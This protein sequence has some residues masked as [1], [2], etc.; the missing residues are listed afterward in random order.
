MSAR[1]DIR[2][3]IGEVLR[4]NTTAGANVFVSRTRKISAASLPAILV[5]TRQE[6]AEEFNTAPRELKRTLSVGIEIVA[7]ADD[8]LDDT[9]DDLAEEVER[10]LSENQLLADD[11]GS[12][13]RCSDVAY[14]GAEISLTADGDNQHGACVLS[15]DVTYHTL[16]VSEG[17]EGAGV[18]SYVVLREMNTAGFAIKAPPFADGQPVASGTIDLPQD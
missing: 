8:D 15:Y 12:N 3:K 13:E 2:Q 9:L 16:D 14:K 18:P 11:D 7:R 6:A 5:Y 10:I 17:V 1:K 4:G